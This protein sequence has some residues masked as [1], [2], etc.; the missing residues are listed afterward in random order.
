MFTLQDH[1]GK[2]AVSPGIDCG[3]V[4]RIS[5]APSLTAS[6][7]WVTVCTTNMGSTSL[8]RDL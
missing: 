8:V 2:T 3:E 5:L 1:T 7:N 4:I 6:S